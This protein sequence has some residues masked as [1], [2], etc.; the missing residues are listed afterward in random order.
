MIRK[1]I[2]TL[3]T[4]VFMVLAFSA[5]SFAANQV[6]MKTTVPNIPKSTCYQAGTDTMEM[7]DNSNMVEGDVIEYT[8]NNKVTICK[9][10]NM[11]LTLAENDGTLDLTGDLPVS[12]TGGVLVS[13][14]VLPAGQQWGFRIQGAVGSQIIRLTLRRIN[15]G[16]G[17]LVPMA[18]FAVNFD[19]TLI[20]DKLVVKLFD[21]KVGVWPESG[22]RKPDVAP[23]AQDIYI[24]NIASSD[25]TLCIDTLTQDFLGEYVQNTPNSIPVNVAQKLNFSGDYVI[26]HILAPQTY[27]LYTCKGVTCGNIPMGTTTQSTA[28]CLAFDYETIG[29]NNNGYCTNHTATA[30]NKPAWILQSS[31]PFELTGYVVSAEILVN[32]APGARGVYWSST[33]PRW[34]NYAT[35]AEACNTDTL[36][37]AWAP[38]YTKA[39]GTTATPI[40]P[41]T[42]AC[43]GVAAG[44]KA[45]KWTTPVTPLFVADDYFLEI[46]LPPYNYNLAEVNAGDVVSVR[47]TLSKSTCGVVGTFDLC[48]GTFIAECPKAPSGG[49]ST[50]FPYFTSLTD[51]PQWWN[52]IAIVNASGTAGTAT[53]TAYEKDGSTATFVTPTI[54]ANSMF[55]S[56]VNAIP[57]VGT[58]L[59]GSPAYISV[60]S[61]FPTMLGFGMIASPATGESM[62][63]LSK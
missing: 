37:N 42:G 22:F 38:A 34:D 36:G 23:A 59:G 43:A 51:D 8:L 29:T 28:T 44:A 32:G 60:T 24:V 18:N 61:T 3:L 57:W 63:Y 14:P 5:M 9:N 52:G 46:D 4:A 50:S 20:T 26:A 7:D 30:P 40:A 17:V 55:V 53:L 21:G 27:N 12:T 25:N 49:A 58:G 10:I 2:F 31:Q 1:K 15:T 56:L 45:V 35:A 54:A 19:G 11:F 13:T 39:D 48:M 47:V 41:S 62:G 33:Q 6:V 16:T